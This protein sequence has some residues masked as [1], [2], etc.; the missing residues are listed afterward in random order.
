LTPFATSNRSIT[1]IS[2]YTVEIAEL[3]H[4]LRQRDP[5]DGLLL[6]RDRGASVAL[7]R[8]DPRER[9][10]R[11]VVAGK[12]SQRRSVLALGGSDAS[13]RP[14]E[15]AELEPRPGL[16]LALATRGL[17]RKLHRLDRLGH[18]SEQLES[19]RDARVRG[20]AGAQRHHRVERGEGRRVSAELDQGIARDAVRECGRG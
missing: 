1:P 9:V 2:A 8:F 12:H 17:D 13:D 11:V 14:V 18:A 6:E 10:E 7:R 15:L 16:G 20:E 3:R 5:V 19:V 4:V